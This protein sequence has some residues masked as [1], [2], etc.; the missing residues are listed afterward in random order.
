VTFADFGN[1]AFAKVFANHYSDNFANVELS[2]CLLLDSD[3]RDRMMGSLILGVLSQKSTA[4]FCAGTTPNFKDTPVATLVSFI[5]DLPRSGSQLEA[6]ANSIC[7]ASTKVDIRALMMV[8]QLVFDPAKTEVKL[9]NPGSPTPQ[10]D[11]FIACTT[12]NP[13]LSAGGKF[14]PSS[15][16]SKANGKS[17]E[18]SR[19]RSDRKET[20]QDCD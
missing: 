8:D 20:S 7:R 1:D 4:A 11:R 10:Y 12:A 18:S 9:N 16:N 14:I 6:I 5:N 17:K 19:C 15:S 2:V 3:L 13:F